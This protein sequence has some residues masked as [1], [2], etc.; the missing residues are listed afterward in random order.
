MDIDD[1]YSI[2]CSTGH[3]GGPAL[4]VGAAIQRCLVEDRRA[5]LAH[6]V[7]SVGRED[8]EDVFQ[9]FVLRALERN[10]DLRD[11]R[12]LR[13]WLGRVLASTIADHRRRR[14]RDRN[15]ERWVAEAE[16]A[17]IP[18]IL[19]GS[20]VCACLYKILPTL[21]ESHATILRRVDLLGEP[22]N[23]IAFELG[24]TP[25]NADVRLHRARRALRQALEQTCPSCAADGYLDCSCERQ[26]HNPFAASGR[27]SGCKEVPT[28][29][30]FRTIRLAERDKC[31]D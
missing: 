7:R 2:G 3:T 28:S 24:I 11:R 26:S 12:A 10:Q 20:A 4:A 27:A 1:T 13:S 25:G 17:N 5:I 9:H 8:A 22:R 16:I 18:D 30:S 6:L 31:M 23:Q 19:P 21:R 29:T 15:R 14:N